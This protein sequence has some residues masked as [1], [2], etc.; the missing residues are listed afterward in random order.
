MTSLLYIGNYLNSKHSNVSSIHVLGALLEAEGY[1]VY[2]SS[3]K[4]NK[5]L[6]LLA[7][8]YSCFKYRNRVGMVIIDTYSTQ[9]FYYALLCSQLCRLFGL[10]YITNLN[11]GNLPYRLQNYPKLSHM[12]FA[13]AVHNV[14]PSL[15][16][17]NA[18]EFH[19][20]TNLVYIPNTIELNKY[21]LSSRPFDVPKLL[22]VRSFSKLYHP[23]LAV[24]VL[25][26]L[27]QKGYPAELCMVG[28][29]SDGTLQDV[30]ELAKSLKVEVRITGKL[31]KAKWIKLSKAYNVFINT[32]NFDNA[33]LS[34]IEAMALGLP[35]VSTNVGGMPFLIKDTEQGLLVP[36]NNV[37][38]MVDAIIHLFKFPEQRKTMISNA[39][40]HTAQFDWQEVKPLWKAVLNQK[41]KTD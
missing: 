30:Q 36:P 37:K 25:K 2:Y 24:Q 21:P 1:V 40:A 33:P 3:K 6:R 31:S 23:E 26:A 18:F 35:I 27:I 17:K 15:Y 8:L 19:G 11:G 9:N 14:A 38:A 13:H 12:L 5:A 28:P 4:I 22:W 10:P 32:T 34:V 16:L 20:Y 39:R 41:F 29:D 7:M